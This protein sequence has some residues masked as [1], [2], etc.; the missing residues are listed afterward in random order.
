MGYVSHW[1]EEALSEKSK[2]TYDNGV[3]KNK[4]KITD[5]EELNKVEASLTFLSLNNLSLKP[6]KFLFDAE[7]YLSIHKDIFKNIYFFAGEIRD[8]NIVKGTTFFARPGNILEQLNEVMNEMKN[9]AINI[10]SRE[11]YID[12]MAKYYDVINMIHPFREG[13]GRTLREFFRQM[14]EYMNQ[15]LDFN[16]ELNYAN[17]SKEA[18]DNLI[19]GSILAANKF[20]LTLLKAFFD[21]VLQEKVIEKTKK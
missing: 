9:K 15:F 12:F 19:N 13:N 14:V 1:I 21:E 7:Y 6:K 2:Y 5:Q 10:N 16:F 4:L 17:I 11:E 20:D 3:L 18:R 8:E